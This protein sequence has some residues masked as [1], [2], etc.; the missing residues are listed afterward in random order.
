[1]YEVVRQQ[2]TGVTQP[3]DLIFTAFNPLLATVDAPQLE[4]QVAELLR[5]S[6]V[7]AGQHAIVDQ[8][9]TEE[10]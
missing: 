7:L 6:G 3:Y 10:K 4:K 8:K 1:V 2:T 5:R 9:K